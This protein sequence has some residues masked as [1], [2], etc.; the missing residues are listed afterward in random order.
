[1]SISSVNSTPP[2]DEASGNAPHAKPR[3]RRWP[4][5]VLGL[6]VALLAFLSYVQAQ[7]AV[8]R[9]SRSS[10]I[11][12]PA[13][14]IFPLVNNVHT[15][16]DWSP[17]A[18]L[19]PNCELTFSGPEAGTGARY[20]WSGNDAIG[21]GSCEVIESIPDQRVRSRLQFVR[22]FE[23]ESE[24]QFTLQPAPAG[25]QVTWEM[26]GQQNFFG[27]LIGLFLD[28]EAMVGAD[29]ESG[30]ANLKSIAE[31]SPELLDTSVPPAAESLPAG[32]APASE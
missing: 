11:D 19:D 12:A 29:F 14:T 10:I 7:P 13:A 30:L 8:F 16:Q 21:A 5:V 26:T 4:L 3:A 2:A 9:V 1:M 17:W 6:A 32:A 31:S 27:K 25:T 22:P 23:D 15:M 18:K 28:C 24:V 20:T